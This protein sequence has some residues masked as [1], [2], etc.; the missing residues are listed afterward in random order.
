VAAEAFVPPHWPTNT[1]PVD[2][3]TN[4]GSRLSMEDFVG[5]YPA[6]QRAWKVNVRGWTR[7]LWAK[8]DM[9]TYRVADE[10]HFTAMVGNR[11]S[12]HFGSIKHGSDGGSLQTVI[13]WMDESGG[14]VLRRDTTSVRPACSTCGGFWTLYFDVPSFAKTGRHRLR[15]RYVHEKLGMD[16]EQELTFS[17]VNDGSWDD[18]SILDE[19]K[20]KHGAV[21]VLQTGRPCKALSIEAYDGVADTY[22]MSPNS[23]PDRRLDHCNFGILPELLVGRYGPEK[24]TLLRFDLACVPK[25]ATVAAAWM[26]LY[27]SP[28]HAPREGT[29]LGLTAYE[30]R[31]PWQA[32]R[33][34]GSRWRENP[35]VDDEASWQCH[36]YPAKWTVPGCAGEGTDRSA[37]PVGQSGPVRERKCWVTMKLDTGLVSR[38]VQAPTSNHGLLLQ[39]DGNCGYYHASEFE[40]PAMRPRLILAFEKLLEG[41]EAACPLPGA[42]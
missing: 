3:P 11:D 24:R 37:K 17:V 29:K 40:D 6:Q 10:V 9:G 27:L 26:Q 13:H 35:V 39:H 2:W 22:M 23:V 15:L 19:A 33:G 8:S 14:K 12:E 4:P 32:G 16:V 25:S 20:A 34:N 30:V 21:V 1:A 7:E 42:R 31:K 18:T 28:R 36:A 38:W 5:K 41:V